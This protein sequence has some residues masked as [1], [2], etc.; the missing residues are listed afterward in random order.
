MET[1]CHEC[2]EAVG[3]LQEYKRAPE[4]RNPHPD[5]FFLGCVRVRKAAQAPLFVLSLFQPLL[6]L[7]SILIKG[8][9]FQK[10]LEN[11]FWSF[12]SFFSSDCNIIPCLHS[13]LY[14]NDHGSIIHNNP[15]LQTTHQSVD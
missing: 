3:E 10:Q 8:D 2:P 7:S 4:V 11:L 12:T 5:M 15:N 14:M 6:C 9:A 1:R 13:D